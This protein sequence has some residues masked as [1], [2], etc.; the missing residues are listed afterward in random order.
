MNYLILISIL[1]SFINSYTSS[2]TCRYES[3]VE[4]TGCY[5]GGAS[6]VSASECCY[7][8]TTQP[9]CAGWVYDQRTYYCSL[10][11]NLN[12]RR[13]R[14]GVMSGSKGTID[15]LPGV[16]TEST[17]KSL[18][19]TSS[20]VVQSTTTKA[21]G[22]IIEFGINYPGNDIG[23]QYNVNSLDE[24]CNLCGSNPSC[25]AFAYMDSAKYCFF[26]GSS[27]SSNRQTYDGIISGVVTI[28]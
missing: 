25:Q 10:I 9:L 17:T 24:C 7:L 18:S 16:V 28:R 15:S 13:Y 4:Y 1:L 8:C 14:C 27:D 23:G 19:T 6:Y 11:G 3:N 12:Y 5:I 2:L 20:N 22:C 21:S 26:K